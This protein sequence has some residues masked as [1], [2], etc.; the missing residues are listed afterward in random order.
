MTLLTAGLPAARAEPVQARSS[1]L[2][3]AFE[4]AGEA[5]WCDAT[6]V[7]HLGA[8]KASVYQPEGAPFLRMIGRIRAIIND[9]CPKVERVLFVGF[10]KDRKVFAAEMTRLTR[11]RRFIALDPET[12]G[13]TCAPLPPDD[14]ECQKRTAA[15]ATV[16][17][18]MQGPAFADVALTAV[19]ENRNDLHAAWE[20]GG[21]SGALKLSHTS[22]FDGRYTTP[23]AFADANSEGLVEACEEEKGQSSRIPGPDLGDKI[24][25]RSVL[26]RRPDQP[27]RLN[28]VLVTS[29]DDW[30]YLFSLWAEEPHMAAA[31]ALARQLAEALSAKR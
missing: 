29:E 28:V 18:L 1:E 9:Q 13:P 21:A 6:V 19:M 14:P 3:I 26:C 15:Y 22:D 10:E 8:D 11:W 16:M 2:G 23:L 24:A 27:G 17:Q 30:F 20:G 4:L 25:L 5:N 31:D 12:E 7:V